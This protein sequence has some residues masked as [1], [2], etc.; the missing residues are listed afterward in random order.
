VQAALI[1]FRGEHSCLWHTHSA[2]SSTETGSKELL[3][4]A[5]VTLRSACGSKVPAWFCFFISDL[6]FGAFQ[7]TVTVLAIDELLTSEA[8]KGEGNYIL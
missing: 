4:G 2:G 1:L 5:S 7:T 6:Y 3:R 8:Y